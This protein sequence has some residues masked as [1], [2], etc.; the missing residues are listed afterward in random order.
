ME[1]G[2]QKYSVSNRAIRSGRAICNPTTKFILFPMGAVCYRGDVS[3]IKPYPIQVRHS[4][5]D[6]LTVSITDYCH[7]YMVVG[8]PWPLIL[9]EI[10]KARY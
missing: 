2:L 1:G 3:C 5:Q 6:A 10:G 4:S 9:F 7:E 8:I